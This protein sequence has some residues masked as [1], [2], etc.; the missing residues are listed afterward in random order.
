VSH[1]GDPGAE[2]DEPRLVLLQPVREPCEHGLGDVLGRV[3]VAN[4][5]A[6]VREHEVRVAQVEQPQR[7]VVSVARTL[8]RLL[9][10]VLPRGRP[11]P[12]PACEPPP[13]HPLELIGL[14]AD[15]VR[16][17]AGVMHPCSPLDPV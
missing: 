8:H 3:L 6:D 4:D 14:E 15:G 17:N 1:A 5:R 16:A 13:V 9:D 10:E 2:R 12:A 11:W 7:V